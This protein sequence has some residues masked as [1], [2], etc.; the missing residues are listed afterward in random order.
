ME[1]QKRTKIVATIGPA[2]QTSEILEELIRK[3]VNV[4]RLNFSHGTHNSHLQ[5]I[6]EIKKIRKK[7]QRSVAILQDLTGPKIRLGKIRNEP[8]QVTAGDTLI[9]DSTL[10]ESVARDRVGINYKGFARDVFPGA[11][12]LLADGDLELVVKAVEESAVICEVVIGGNLYSHKGVNFPSGTFKVPTLTDKDKKD[13]LFGLQNGIDLVAMSFVRSAADLQKVQAVFKKAGRSVPVIA[14]IEKHEAIENL[15]QIMDAF[16]AVM[17]ARGD[18]GVDIDAE[19]VPFIQK[20]IIDLANRSG[21]PVITATQMLRSMVDSPIPT[22]AEVNDVANAVLDGTDAIMLS[23]ETAVGKY[24]V[25]AVD[26]MSKIARQ[27]EEY[28]D[29]FRDTRIA[30]SA[31]SASIPDSI[32]HSATVVARDLKARIIFAITR[33]GYTAR[34]IARYRPQSCILALTPEEDVYQQLSL[35]WG[36][37]PVKNSLQEDPGVL[38]REALT[39]AKKLKVVRKNDHY[40]FT[41]GYPLGKPGSINQV[42]AGKIP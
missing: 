42:T 33:T 24:P 38:F 17:V 40:V 39:I 9:L 34:A 7:L 32:S 21:K 16:D 6:R 14:K 23:E 10:N 15:N 13:L 41:S 18:L 2:S 30:K 31:V 35:V 25:K 5:T 4:F 12:L 28:I 22:R 26:M 27:A 20:R 3:G 36:V 19:K 29:Y 1:K 11:R 8:L 37:F